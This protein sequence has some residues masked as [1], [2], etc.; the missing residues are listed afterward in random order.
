MGAGGGGGVEFRNVA[1]KIR[2]IYKLFRENFITGKIMAGLIW[3]FFGNSAIFIP[4][5]IF[6]RNNITRHN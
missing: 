1:G 4:A 6:T 5:I 3:Q 2:W